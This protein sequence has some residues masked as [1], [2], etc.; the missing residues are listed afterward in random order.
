MNGKLATVEAARKLLK[1]MYSENN[2]VFEKFKDIKR[3]KKIVT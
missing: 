3:K 1:R 2:A